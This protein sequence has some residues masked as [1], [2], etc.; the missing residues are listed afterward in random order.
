MTEA[1][2]VERLERILRLHAGATT[3]GEREAARAAAA[4]VEERLR[5]LRTEVATEHRFAVD[6]P[7][8]RRLLVALLR[9]HGFPPYRHRGQRRTTVMARMPA[10]YCTEVLWPEFVAL[11]STLVEYLEQVASRVIGEAL[12]QES[13]EAPVVEQLATGGTGR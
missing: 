1:E 12:K 8:S 4:R 13:T 7:W 11:D 9:K 3:P 6:N 2:L 5:E 10:R